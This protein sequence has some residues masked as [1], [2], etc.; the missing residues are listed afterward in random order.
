VL[1]DRAKTGQPR[2]QIDG[3]YAYVLTQGNRIHQLTFPARIDSQSGES[4]GNAF[5]GIDPKTLYAVLMDCHALTYINTA[6]LASIAAHAK[7]LHLR[8]FRI[9]EPVRKVF[10]IVGLLQMLRVHTSLQA[11][12]DP[13]QRARVPTS[14]A[15]PH[16][17]RRR[18]RLCSNERTTVAAPARSNASTRPRETLSDAVSMAV[19]DPH[20]LLQEV[21]LGD[22]LPRSGLLAG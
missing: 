17:A 21:N 10:E 7:R 11:A 14:R 20:R 16:S 12:L 5:A 1:A 2:Q 22:P 3:P 15:R 9:S 8:L 13:G 18:M 4:M 19:L 6:G